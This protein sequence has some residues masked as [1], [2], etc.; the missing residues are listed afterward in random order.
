VEQEAIDMT[1]SEITAEWKYRYEERLGILCGAETPTEEQ[2]SIARREAD[3]AIEK[4]KAD[5]E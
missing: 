5:C 2:E 1:E 3:G 4:L